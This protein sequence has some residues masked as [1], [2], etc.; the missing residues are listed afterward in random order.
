MQGGTLCL[1]CLLGP[2]R[3]LGE[4]ADGLAEI[5][6]L[7]ERLGAQRSL[8]S[9]LHTAGIVGKLAHL[10]HCMLSGLHICLFLG[11]QTQI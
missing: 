9:C 11:P 5:G 8:C 1:G 6:A 10:H 7:V 4:V 2:L 3:D